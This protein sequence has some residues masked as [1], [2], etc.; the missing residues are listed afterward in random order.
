MLYNQNKFLFIYSNFRYCKNSSSTVELTLDSASRTSIMYSF[1]SNNV[2]MFCDEATHNRFAPNKHNFMC[3]RKSTLDVILKHKDFAFSNK[4]NR[5]EVSKLS[6]TKFI[7][8]QRPQFTRYAIIIDET[9]DMVI[10]E[11]WS[12]LR[13]AIRKW[14]MYDL[15]KNTEISILLANETGIDKKFDFQ[16]LSDY[17]IRDNI[18]SFFPYAPID[19]RQ[20]ACIACAIK[21]GIKR[22]QIQSHLKPGGKNVL[23][24]I[25]PGIDHN[26]DLRALSSLIKSNGFRIITINY[27]A[28]VRRKPLDSL[29]FMTE[30]DAY[31]VYESKYNSEKSLLKTYFDL[32]NVLHYISLSN[33][34]GNKFKLPIEIYRKEIVDQNKIVNAMAKQVSRTIS[35]SFVLD[36]NMAMP[37]GFYIYTHNVEHPLIQSIKLVSPTG[38]TYTSISDQ[39]LLVKQLTVS[40]SFNETGSWT[41]TIQ[42]FNGNPQSHFIQVKYCLLIL[43]SF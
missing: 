42:R 28:I 6:Y 5:H 9:Q 23:V 17:R 7:Y 1:E 14:I 19:S 20:Q 36:E 27:P 11:S 35:G 25:A 34:H 13:N 15:S 12:F 16:K 30:G 24:V 38:K 3:E 4:E 33:Y 40:A 18:A 43:C 41:Y 22:M 26:T 21:D 31:S 2:K 37:G 8:A 10:R 32:T 39:R 29:A